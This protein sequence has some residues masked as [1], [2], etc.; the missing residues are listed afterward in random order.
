MICFGDTG[1][2]N[3]R[4]HYYYLPAGCW[5]GVCRLHEGHLTASNCMCNSDVTVTTKKM[6]VRTKEGGRGSFK[7]LDEH[8]TSGGDV[9]TVRKMRK[10][11]ETGYGTTECLR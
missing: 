5:G 8:D 9:E 6:T 4:C 1:S 10:E 2:G 7:C 3:C 11:G